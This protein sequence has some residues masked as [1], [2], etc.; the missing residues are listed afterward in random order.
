MI[1]LALALAL[2]LA[3]A[4][5][6][7]PAPVPIPAPTLKGLQPLLRKT[8]SNIAWQRDLRIW[9]RIIV[10]GQMICYLTT[11]LGGWCSLECRKPR[12]PKMSRL[13]TKL[14]GTSGFL[15][16]SCCDCTLFLSDELSQGERQHGRSSKNGQ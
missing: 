9:P 13:L 5:A 14:C 1:F 11:T 2:V 6:P 16:T 8:Y 12:A 15:H 4:P 10:V 7:A 3:L